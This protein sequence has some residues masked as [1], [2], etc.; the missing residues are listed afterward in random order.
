MDRKQM[1]E[2]RQYFATKIIR[3]MMKI[4]WLFP[5]ERNKVFCISSTGKYYYDSAKYITQYLVKYYPEKFKIVWAVKD[6]ESPINKDAVFVKIFSPKHFF[7]FCTAK[8]I[9]TNG[10]MPT[11]LPKR[12]SQIL[13]NTWH[14]GG[15]YKRSTPDTEYRVLLNEYKSK[16]T[17]IFTSSCRGFSEM[18]IPDLAPKFAGEIMPCGMPRNDIFFS[19]DR[20]RIRSEVCQKLKINESHLIIFYAPTFRGWFDS[21]TEKGGADLM[22][23]WSLSVE[24]FCDAVKKR[25]NKNVTFIFKQH[26]RDKSIPIESGINVADYPD[27]QELLCTADILISD[28]SSTIW[29]FSLMKK[30]CF[31]YVPDLDYYLKNDRGVYTPVETWPG[32]MARTNKELQEAVL[33][34]DEE[35]YIKKVE[36]HHKDLGSYE[37]GTA[38]EQVCKRIAEFCCV[39][40]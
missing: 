28:Y 4:L 39:K 37:S 24:E 29:D 16:C 23:D 34:F 25:F 40:N 2:M 10:G 8:V 18:T 21:M 6:V 20:G 1:S 17:D 11:Y 38:C 31:L 7:H 14:G 9:V 13:I 32:I 36:K 12:Q 22:H 19:E 30:P 27:M 15:A 35:V 33:K 26:F 5:V 3:Q